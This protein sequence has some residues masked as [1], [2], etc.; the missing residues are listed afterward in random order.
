M[1]NKR[2]RISDLDEKARIDFESAEVAA[3]IFVV[4]HV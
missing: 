4:L 1:E 3:G 2:L